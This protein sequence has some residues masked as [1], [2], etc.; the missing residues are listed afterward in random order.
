MRACLECGAQLPSGVRTGRPATY[1]GTVCRR[2]AEYRLRRLQTLTTRAQR[3]EQDARLR[4]TMAEAW[5][6]ATLGKRASF[7]ADEVT[8]LEGRIRDLLAGVEAPEGS[9]PGTVEPQP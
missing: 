2:S 7:W 5:D 6:G 9:T 3:A 4:L 1:C 8:R